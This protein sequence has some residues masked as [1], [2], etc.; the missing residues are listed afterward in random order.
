[1]RGKINYGRSEFG[2]WEGITSMEESVC[3]ICNKSDDKQVYEIKKTA[4][5]RLVASSKKR[6]DNKYKKF[7]T[8]TSALIHRTC[9]SHYNDETAIAAFCSSRLIRK[10]HRRPAPPRSEFRSG[11]RS[12]P[13][14]NGQRGLLLRSTTHSSVY[15]TSIYQSSPKST[16]DKNKIR[17]NR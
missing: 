13:Y 16:K 3:I 15:T 1:M 5:N 9:Q 2:K 4:L 12:I 6:I 17:E 7:E 10:S 14:I 11:V 8:L